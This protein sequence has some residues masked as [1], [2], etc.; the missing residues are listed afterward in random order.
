MFLKQQFE[1]FCA[2]C[3]QG[4]QWAIGNDKWQ[5][6]VDSIKPLFEGNI[7]SNEF[8]EISFMFYLFSYLCLSYFSLYFNFFGLYN[9]GITIHKSCNLVGSS[10]YLWDIVYDF[11]CKIK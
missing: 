4:F 6:R 2:K 5:A 11:I 10:F 1:N 7:T 9:I 8:S 3:L